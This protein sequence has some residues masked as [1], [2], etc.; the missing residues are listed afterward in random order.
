MEQC[1]PSVRSEGDSV[2]G[3]AKEKKAGST[4]LWLRPVSGDQMRLVVTQGDLDLSGVDRTLGG[5][6][7][8]LPLE[9]PVSRSRAI[10]GFFSPF[11]FLSRVGHHITS[12]CRL[13]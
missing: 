12:R 9:R 2:S 6:V 1:S 3:Q 11:P 8:S 10:S 13:T 4:G 7:R 5:R